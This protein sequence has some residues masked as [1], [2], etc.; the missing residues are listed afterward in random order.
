MAESILAF[1]IAANIITFID[2]SYK[3][4]STGYGLYVFGSSKSREHQMLKH[5][6]DD[7]H[8]VTENLEES[9]QQEQLNDSLSID[10]IE[11]QRLAEQCKVICLELKEALQELE[12]YD[13]KH[14][15]NT[16]LVALRSIWKED[17]IKD[18]QNNVEQFRQQLI[19]HLLGSFR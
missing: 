3:V 19:I 17:K 11:L 9:L 7:L 4:F 14:K 1:G 15:W 5:V 6:T 8:R 2:F 12:V 18:L 13:P 16:F 10:E